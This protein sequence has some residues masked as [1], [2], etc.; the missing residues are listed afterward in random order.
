MLFGSIASIRSAQ[1]IYATSR[2]PLLT[3]DSRE[4]TE[5][6]LAQCSGE[7]SAFRVGP[8]APDFADGGAPVVLNLCDHDGG[9]AAGEARHRRME[10]LYVDRLHVGLV[11][12]TDEL[13]EP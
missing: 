8:D 3:E 2:F 4:G 12:Q 10:L 7:P 5:T 6:H 13:R 1:T 11:D 9:R